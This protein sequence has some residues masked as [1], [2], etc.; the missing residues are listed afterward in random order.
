M[1]DISIYWYVNLK[2][3]QLPTTKGKESAHD[4]ICLSALQS[5]KYSLRHYLGYNPISLN[6]KSGRTFIIS[7]T[8]QEPENRPPAFVFWLYVLL[9]S[10]C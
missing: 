3:N 4:S 6:F 9:L 8:E 1:L 5:F 7:S 10:L 2:Q